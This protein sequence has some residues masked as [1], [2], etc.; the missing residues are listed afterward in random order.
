MDGF[1]TALGVEERKPM[2]KTLPGSIQRV[3]VKA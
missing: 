1:L 2:D 3:N